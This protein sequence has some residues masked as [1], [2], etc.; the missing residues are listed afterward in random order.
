[1]ERDRSYLE[2]AMRLKEKYNIKCY[3]KNDKDKLY[4]FILYVPY[5]DGGIIR[6]Y[7]DL[8]VDRLL[9]KE[10]KLTI[11]E[12]RLIKRYLRLYC[13]LEDLVWEIRL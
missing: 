8:D 4:S 3:K 11:K 1:M 12:L 7:D 6:I 9:C 2:L 5:I 13:D 10:L